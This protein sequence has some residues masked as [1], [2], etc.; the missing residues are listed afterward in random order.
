MAATEEEVTTTK[1]GADLLGKPKYKKLE[2]GRFKCVQTGHE[3]LEK[4]KK[5]YSQSKR[6]RLGLI[7][8]ALSH[9]KP[10]LNLFEQDPNARSKLKC[11][12]TGDT[13]NKTEEHIWKHITG[14]R[15]LNRLE[16][17]ERE[18][19]SGSIPAEGGE[20]P[21]KENGVEDEDKK[22]KKKK[23]NK[24]KKNK[25]SVEKKKNGE[26]VADEIEHENDEAVEEE[27]EFWMPPDGERWDFDDGRDR[28][29][30]DSDSDVEMNEETDPIGEFDEDG[31][32]SMEESILIGE[33]DEDGKIVLDDT[34]ASN[35][36]KHEELGS[37]DLP[38]KKKNKKKKKKK[39]VEATSSSY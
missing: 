11:K 23:N 14:R 3:L 32:I 1:E 9:S 17:K 5:V 8:Y 36:R 19:E 12:L 26:D 10:P 6:C 29:G 34:H 16:E 20:T 18:K 31:E 24:K 27:L 2:N 39:N 13:V 37:S 33:V 30:S 22:K 38:S 25:K 35:K 21:A 4:D 15:F 7:D 28:W